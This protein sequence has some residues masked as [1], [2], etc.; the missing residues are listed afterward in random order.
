M[1]AERKRARPV[2]EKALKYQVDK[3]IVIMGKRIR[4]PN[5]K[6]MLVVQDVKI[7]GKGEPRYSYYAY[8]PHDRKHLKRITAMLEALVE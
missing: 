4:W 2:V 6:L 1:I 8:L 7:D 3:A 5:G